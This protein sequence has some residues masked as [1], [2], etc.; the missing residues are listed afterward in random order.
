M[1]ALHLEPSTAAARWDECMW[2]WEHEPRSVATGI[3]DDET[4][5]WVGVVAG[6]ARTGGW[7]VVVD[8]DHLVEAHR[9]VRDV[10]GID[11]D[12]TGSASLAGLLAVRGGIGDTER[13]AVLVTGV[14]RS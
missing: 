1:G 6:M 14:R 8:E 5:D 3:L 12:P 7:P 11:A 2:P 10:A 4:Y 9:L 13:V